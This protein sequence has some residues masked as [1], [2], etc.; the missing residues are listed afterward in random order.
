MTLEV[1]HFENPWRLSS[2]GPPR[3]HI[4]QYRSIVLVPFRHVRGVLIRLNTVAG[5]V[6]TERRSGYLW[7]VKTERNAVP[8]FLVLYILAGTRNGWNGPH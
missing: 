5:T 8:V 7:E 1:D 3:R 4:F 2:S 6:G